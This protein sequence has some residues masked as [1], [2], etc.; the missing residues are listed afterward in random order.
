MNQPAPFVLRVYVSGT[1]LISERSAVVTDEIQRQMPNLII[2]IVDINTLLEPLPN[3]VFSVPTYVLNGKVISLGNPD[4][5]FINK[6]RTLLNDDD[7]C[8]IAP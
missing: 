2:E 1:C 5:D 8:K 3:V 7:S 4:A 6:L